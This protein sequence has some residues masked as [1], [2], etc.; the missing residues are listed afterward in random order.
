MADVSPVRQVTWDQKT[1]SPTDLG[2]L[3]RDLLAKF[4]TIPLRKIVE[5][6]QLYAEPMYLAADHNPT[7]ITCL[8]VRQ[9]NSQE[10]PVL[11]GAAV[12]WVWDSNRAKINSIDGMT[13]GST[14]YIFT[15]ELVG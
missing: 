13:P 2:E 7:A 3:A 1:V 12:H 4:A 8:R 14:N 10:A 15:F 11:S 6:T 5:V 9:Q